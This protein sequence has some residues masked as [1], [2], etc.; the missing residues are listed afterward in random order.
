MKHLKKFNNFN[1][2]FSRIEPEGG[3][4][5]LW[6]K[7][8]H[9]FHDYSSSGLGTAALVDRKRRK[10]HEEEY[11]NEPSPTGTNAADCVG[12]S[13]W[14]KVPV[15]DKISSDILSK[16]ESGVYNIEKSRGEYYCFEFKLKELPNSWCCCLTD[17]DDDDDDDDDV[18]YYLKKDDKEIERTTSCGDGAPMLIKLFNFIKKLPKKGDQLSLKFERKQNSQRK[19][20]KVR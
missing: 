4:S 14:K 15:S 3:L 5:D 12:T 6:Y 9:P 19:S 2:G 20:K 13:D 11:K 7:I 18:I 10:D 16:I 1:E 8:T 17:D